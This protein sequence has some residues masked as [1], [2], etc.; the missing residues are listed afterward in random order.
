MPRNARNEAG[1][2]NAFNF[3]HVRFA[4][5]AVAIFEKRGD[6]IPAGFD[7]RARSWH[8]SA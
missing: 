6:Y 4:I 7:R 5:G 1:V 2:N 8:R 3:P